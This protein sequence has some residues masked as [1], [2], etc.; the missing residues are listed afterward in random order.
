[1]MV[2]LMV[3]DTYLTFANGFAKPGP[4]SPELPSF[5]EEKSGR[6]TLP[7]PAFWSAILVPNLLNMV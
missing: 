2:G 6:E 4:A 7:R 1:M 3:S 5:F